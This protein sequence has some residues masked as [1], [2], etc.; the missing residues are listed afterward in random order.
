MISG[1]GRTTQRGCSDRFIA[2]ISA[3]SDSMLSSIQSVSMGRKEPHS[4]RLPDWCADTT[5]FHIAD[6]YFGGC[7]EKKITRAK[8]SLWR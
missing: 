6:K 8:I 7:E 4:R 5:D 1:S 2:Q 3:A